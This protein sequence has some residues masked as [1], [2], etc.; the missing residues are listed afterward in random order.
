MNSLSQVNKIDNPALEFYQKGLEEQ[1]FLFRF[2]CYWISFCMLY[3]ERFDYSESELRKRIVKQAEKENREIHDK[4]KIDVFCDDNLQLLMRADLFQNVE[5]INVLKERGEGIG[6]PVGLSDGIKDESGIAD[7]YKS[8]YN[9][10]CNLF[11]GI[12]ALKSDRTKRLMKAS[13]NLLETTLSVFFIKN[14]Q[15]AAK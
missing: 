4:E 15:V 6:R 5:D 8:I 11:H 12:K 7:I 14:Y 3:T 10:R 9:V 13:S 2:F 1:D